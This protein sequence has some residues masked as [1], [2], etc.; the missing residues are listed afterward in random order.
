MPKKP[1]FK[2]VITRVKLEPEQAVLLC[3][4][5]DTG[6]GWWN[7]V[8]GGGTARSSVQFT[9][10]QAYCAYFNRA[11]GAFQSTGGSFRYAFNAGAPS[12]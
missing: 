9:T 6:G 2:P 1:K 8:A 11:W 5:Y 10:R 3:G 12:S 4:C 7:F